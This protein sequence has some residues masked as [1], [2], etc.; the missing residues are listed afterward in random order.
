VTGTGVLVLCAILGIT[1]VAMASMTCAAAA[2]LIAHFRRI[3]IGNS[4]FG[5]IKFLDLL[6]HFV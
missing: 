6:F 5:K 3:K 1:S 2:N 4:P